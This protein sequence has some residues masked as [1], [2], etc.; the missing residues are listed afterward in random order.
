MLFLNENEVSVIMEYFR[1]DKI[2]YIHGFS[3]F[4]MD[5]L[6]S[7]AIPIWPN[8]QAN[9]RKGHIIKQL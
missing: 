1:E 7:E 9:E 6:G 8:P 3:V 2:P 5:I 4:D